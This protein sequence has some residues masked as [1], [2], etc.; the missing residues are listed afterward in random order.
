MKQYKLLNNIFGWLAFAISATAYILTLEPT[1]SFWDC[2]EFISSAYKLE[3]GHPPGNPIF[4]L[5]ARFFANFASDPSQVAYMVNLMSGLLSAG[6]ILL[7]FW[8]ITHLAG[9]IV[10]KED[11]D[12]NNMS[13]SHMITI[14]GCGMVG[15][16]AYAF[17]DTFWFSAVEGEVYAYSSFCTA[18]VFWLI[19]KWER[20]AD[21]PHSDRYIVLIAYLIGVSIA[22]HLL[23]LLC[24]PAIVLV[25]YYRKFKNTNVKGSLIA[26]AI[27]FALI[28]LLLYG[29][30][31]GFVKVAGWI[32]L[33]FVNQFHAPFNTGVIIYFFCVI[34]VLV[35]AISETYKQRSDK[36]IKLSFLISAILV[37]LP[38]IS[39]SLWVGILLSAALAI[40]LFY[41]QKKVALRIMNT[42]LVCIMVIFIGYSSYA[43][44]IIR[45]SANT[46]MDQNSP[47]DVFTLSS[48]LNREQYGDRPLV[49]GQTFVADVARNN[50]GSA[51]V[52]EG[53]AIWRRAIKANPNERDRY[54]V[55]DHK[56]DYIYTPELCML[57]PR[58][59]SPSASPDHVGAYKE[60]TNFKGKPVRVT[61]P[62]GKSRIVMKPTFGENLKFFLDYQLN[63]MYW[64]YFMWNFSGR[65]NDIQG[66]GEVSKGNWITGFNF[67]DK[68]IAG[69]QANLPSDLA[70]NKGHNVFYMLPLILGLI[71]LFFQ[72]YSGKKGI[73][74]FWVTFFLFF[75]TGIAIVI[76]LNQTPYQPRER[77][78]A[79][80]G[81]FY[82]FAIWIGLG[83]AA[84]SKGF[85]R[86]IKPVPSAIIAVL[87]CLCVPIQMVS[88]TWDDHD[89]SGRYT[90]RDFGM[91][92]LSCVDED[93]II[94]TNGDNDT[95][96]LWYAQ[97]T[98]GF[99]TD[100]RVCNLSYLQTD[101]YI[102]QMKSQA[103]TS[104][105]LPISMKR[106]QYGNG[107]REYAYLIDAFKQPLSVDDAM[108]FFLSDDPAT[109]QV[110]GY[111]AKINYF[112]T[113]EFYIP[114][115]SAAVVKAGLVP[116]SLKDKIPAEMN[117]SYKSV[118]TLTMNEIAI[119]D[120]IN[121]NAKNGWK[122]PIYYAVT[123]GPDLYMNLKPYFARVGLANQVTPVA[124]GEDGRVDT[125][126]MYDN[127]IN[128]FRWGGIDNPNVYLDEN[129]RRMCFTHRMMI[130]DLVDAL[131]A[132]GK[133]D[134]A[135]K[136]LDFSM[137]KIPATAIRHD[138]LSLQ[139][140]ANYLLLGEKK[141]GID[142]LCEVADNSME[143][144]KWYMGLT[145]N[146]MRSISRDIQLNQFIM[147]RNVVP[148]LL[149]EG[150]K[151]KALDY[152]GRLKEVGIDPSTYLKDMLQNG[153]E[154]T[155]AAK[156]TDN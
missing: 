38:F 35:W 50:D 128:K 78:Y 136:A 48:Y 8:T 112:P 146:Q 80:A 33:L 102:D 137:E 52:K 81:S 93:G 34:G 98:E 21:Q 156:D 147:V 125:E 145:P 111:S 14:L 22:V 92:Y 133:Y 55:I 44:I 47:E 77:D 18:L 69:D 72:A 43:L 39:D 37:G 62:D 82:A 29:L 95:F 66:N 53:P 83:T 36:L 143:Y 131:I 153:D 110:P 13:L 76:Y 107:K 148:I 58:M 61:D 86:F 100:V 17:S 141:K 96:P 59:Y 138:Y 152:I 12:E 28:V 99:R 139:M 54:V 9:K 118:G 117:L 63:F 46:P 45:S 15:A 121:T 10:L 134:K 60:W 75:M 42:A 74:G 94:F 120:M 154:T 87:L 5:T 7:L 41:F 25:F 144:L 116:D 11:E 90:T 30:V 109:K 4:M 114:I 16:L 57:F 3:V 73:E 132:E 84:L 101:W 151:E 64:R 149:S 51:M 23:N 103:Y 130:S 71:G 129:I 85:S 1:A 127:I 27:S 20:V 26:L 104:D 155:T 32:E 126:K 140:A 122:R 135:L 24:I 19:L 115:D 70:N 79:Y 97:E 65:Q 108:D 6:T 2:G 91:N 106:E 68:Y 119:L 142:L 123:V 88:Q 113:Q 105:P 67:I 89:R 40:Y 124:T 49:Y 150:E 31:P 56:K